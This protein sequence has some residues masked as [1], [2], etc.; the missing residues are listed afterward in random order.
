MRGEQRQF[1]R[2]ACLCWSLA[3][4]VGRGEHRGDEF[5]VP[6]GVVRRCSPKPVIGG[7]QMGWSPAAM[8]VAERRSATS[9]SVA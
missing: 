5:G 8:S 2:R 1:S 9:G 3:V 7:E 4:L 6:G